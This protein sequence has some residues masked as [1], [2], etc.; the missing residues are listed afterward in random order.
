MSQSQQPQD[1]RTILFADRVFARFSVAS[2]TY[3]IPVDEVL[4]SAW[5]EEEIRLDQLNRIVRSVLN[6][7]VVLPEAH[8]PPDDDEVPAVLDCGFG[9]GAWIDDLL[10]EYESDDCEVTGVDLYLGDGTDDEDDDEDS[11]DEERRAVQE[12][13]KKRWNLNETFSADRNPDR[14]TPE[15]FDLINSRLL[16]AG[17]DR[18][19][20][21][22]YIRDLKRLLKPGGWLQM[23][24]LEL[25]FQSDSGRLSLND[26]QP[27]RLWTSWHDDTMLRNNRDT[28]VGRKLRQ[29][30]LDAGFEDI[31]H[32]QESLCVGGWN[33]SE[34]DIVTNRQLDAD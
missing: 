19:R 21:P 9:K 24:E 11:D 25:L 5:Q 3:C 15:S 10:E 2:N 34:H 6:D 33:P 7:H 8:F 29:Y 27:L 13:V 32:R 28:R 12:F 26:D 17:I 20:W 16:A 22:S 31:V 18:D 1:D 23:V 30:L 4:L 14:L